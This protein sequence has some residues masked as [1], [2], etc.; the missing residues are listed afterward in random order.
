VDRIARI[1]ESADADRGQP[2]V[3]NGVVVAQFRMSIPAVKMPDLR[4][5]EREGSMPV[6]PRDPWTALRLAEMMGASLVRGQG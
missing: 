1:W 3:L 4:K 5:L 2:T 6:R